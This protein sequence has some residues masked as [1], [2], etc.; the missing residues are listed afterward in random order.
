MAILG[1]DRL[2]G[3][4]FRPGTRDVDQAVLNAAQVAF[5]AG[6]ASLL[7]GAFSWHPS[8]PE[9]DRPSLVLAIPVAGVVMYVRSV[10]VVATVVASEDALP[11]LRTWRGMVTEDLKAEAFPKRRC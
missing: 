8:R 9:F 11:L 6:A 7:L 3:Y 4:A 10:L 5:Q 2:L 1:L